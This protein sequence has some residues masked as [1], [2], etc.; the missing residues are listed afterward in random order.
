MSSATFRGGD[1]DLTAS[2]QHDHSSRD[3][4]H[5]DGPADSHRD[6]NYNTDVIMCNE[7]NR[8]EVGAR[9]SIQPDLARNPDRVDD[10]AIKGPDDP[11]E[12]TKDDDEDDAEGEGERGHDSHLDQVRERVLALKL[13]AS[14]VRNDPPEVNIVAEHKP[15]EMLRAPDVQ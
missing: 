9:T 5:H 8:E 11:E 1:S 13:S 3:H 15:H 12:V 2:G 4:D 7:N 6:G 10:G 14:Q